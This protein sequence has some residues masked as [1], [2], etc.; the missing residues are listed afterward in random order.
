[1]PY[2]KTAPS[3]SCSQ[4]NLMQ[5]AVQLATKLIAQLLTRTSAMA[6][7]SQ[8]THIAPH[9][10]HVR[11]MANNIATC[12]VPLDEIRDIIYNTIPLT[13]MAEISPKLDFLHPEDVQYNEPQ[14]D[15]QNLALQ[16]IA[17]TSL[18]STTPSLTHEFSSLR[19]PY[20]IHEILT[21][22][23]TMCVC[24]KSKQKIINKHTYAQS[25]L[26]S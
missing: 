20:H 7:L 26:I 22:A 14:Q 19:N 1:M 23:V 18:I 4:C 15:L 10:M 16:H 8:Y 2:T 17:Y 21:T 12:P 9:Q 13:T 24:T 25:V 5:E 11:V 6:I 3:T